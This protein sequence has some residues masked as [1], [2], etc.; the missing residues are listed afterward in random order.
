MLRITGWVRSSVLLDLTLLVTRTRAPPVTPAPLLLKE[1]ASASVHR[2]GI[3]LLT[4][5]AA[6]KNVPLAGLLQLGRGN[7]GA[8]TWAP[9][10]LRVRVNVSVVLQVDGQE[11]AN[12]NA[13]PVR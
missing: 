5:R 12:R 10:L 11:K 6:R 3:P 4:T 8:V 9:T 7:V 2:L 13:R 1:Q